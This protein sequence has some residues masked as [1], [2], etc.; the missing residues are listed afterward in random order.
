MNTMYKFIILIFTFLYSNKINACINGETLIL[1]DGTMLYSDHEDRIPYGH[2]FFIN[3]VQN[4]LTSLDSLYK[5][6]KDNSYLSDKGILLIIKGKYKEAID[7]YLQIE[8]NTPNRYSTAANIGTAYELIGDNENALKWIQKAM[9]INAESHYNSEWI[10]VNILKAKINGFN[11]I[12]SNF[13][14]NTDFG[15]DS[16]PQSTLKRA[17]L[18]KLYDALYYQL[19][20]RVTF[21][22]PE[23]KIVALLLFDLGNIALLIKNHSYAIENYKLAKKYGFTQ[24]IIEARIKVATNPT[25]SET[26][27]QKNPNSY[28]NCWQFLIGIVTVI[29]V[30]LLI[31]KKR[32]L[33]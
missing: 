22:K 4:A 14:I 15:G 25:K 27:V 29:L 31:F 12:N 2:L 32:F 1:R 24:L 3:E 18:E 16:L 26:T 7:L 21:V 13:L 5:L 28:T 19:N 17:E 33:L 8:K 11:A 10:H 9:E 23:D 30:L 6:T 20:E